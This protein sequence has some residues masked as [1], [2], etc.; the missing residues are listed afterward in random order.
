MLKI[1]HRVNTSNELKN[2]SLDYGVE[3]DLRSKEKDIIIHHDPFQEGELLEDYLKSYQH[4]FIILNIKSEGIEERVLDLINKFSITDYFLLDLSLPFTI[5]YIRKGERKIA[6]RFSEYEPIEFALS[7]QNKVDWLWVDC[8]NELPLTMD[9]YEKLKQNYKI[10]LVSPELQGH[11][12]EQIQ[13][14][15][16][17]IDGMKIDAVCTK[18]PD[19]W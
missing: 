17:Q 4:K 5:K 6:V 11:P 18:R 12:I 10:C 1:K 3:L 16:K 15:K 13:H 14:F 19:L 8:F 2:L 9:V 7:F